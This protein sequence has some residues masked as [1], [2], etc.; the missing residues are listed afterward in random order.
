M[1]EY[2][3]KVEKKNSMRILAVY[4]LQPSDLNILYRRCKASSC[5]L[6]EKKAILVSTLNDL[7]DGL[8]F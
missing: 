7:F 6:Y 8:L 1:G 2:V 3:G 4:G 5:N